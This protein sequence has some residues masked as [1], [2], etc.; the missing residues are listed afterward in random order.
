[1]NQ[2][3]YDYDAIINRKQFR[4][5]NVRF[6]NALNENKVKSLEAGRPIYDEIPSISIQ[7]PGG[8]ETVRRIEPQDSRQYPNEWA[9]YQSGLIP[10]TEGTPLSEWAPCPGSVVKE[11]AHLG[12]KTVEQL[13]EASDAVKQ[14]LGTSG[15]F[16]KMAKT[17]LDAANSTQ[18]NVMKLEEQL[19][20]EHERVA[21]LRDQVELLMQRVE[22]SE[23][24]DLREQRKEVIQ[25][26]SVVVSASD[27]AILDELDNLP[28]PSPKGRL[29]KV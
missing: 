6:F 27:P 3:S 28:E 17:W 2:P 8:D 1:M 18:S 4:R 16:I 22:A 23:G 21:K 20:Q 25:S 11:L 15:R 13:A 10:V 29:R 12:F 24:T 9:A 5:P 7:F 19:K 26:A 14:R